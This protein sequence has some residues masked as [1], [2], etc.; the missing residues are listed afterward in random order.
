M[1]LGTHQE[2]VRSSPRVSG[3]CQDS[4]GE[5]ARRRPRLVE[6]LS[7]VAEKLTGSWEGLEVDVLAI[8]IVSGYELDDAVGARREFARRFTEGIRKLARNMPR[9][10]RRKAVDSPLENPNIVGLRE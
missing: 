3:A 6:R 1:W 9:D 2:C 4:V 8:M 5:F 10:R 7:R